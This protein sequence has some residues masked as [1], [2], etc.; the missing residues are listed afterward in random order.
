V[1][2]CSGD[3][4]TA[5]AHARK[6][7]PIRAGRT[8]IYWKVVSSTHICHGVLIELGSHALAL[9]M[10]LKVLQAI[11]QIEARTRGNL[12]DLIATI[13]LEQGNLEWAHSLVLDALRKT[14]TASGVSRGEYLA[15]LGRI[16]LAEGRAG[17]A[18]EILRSA[19]DVLDNGF[20]YLGLLSALS[21]FGLA[22]QVVGRREEGVEQSARAVKLLASRD[23][24]GYRPQEIYWNHF[25]ITRGWHEHDARRALGMAYRIVSKRAAQL[26][27]AKRKRYLSLD[28]NK[29]VIEAW[30]QK[31]GRGR[32]MSSLA[33]GMTAPASIGVTRVAVDVPR[34]GATWGRSLQPHEIVE[35]IW[36]IDAGRHDEILRQSKGEVGLRRARIIRLC[37]EANAQGGDPREEDLARVLGVSVRTIRADIAALRAMGCHLQTRGANLHLEH[38]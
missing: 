13:A 17:E 4:S 12:L 2:G 33:S 38:N 29:K 15:T 26:G 8:D 1:Y 32:A 21:G 34:T 22:L 14:E 30:E 20:S 9:R 5:L 27:T 16:M 18:A 11:P 23:G 36:T 31:Y 10:G 28:V 25:L 35:V 3:L 19:V 37:A 7:L 24:F 6:G